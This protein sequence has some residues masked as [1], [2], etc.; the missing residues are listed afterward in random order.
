MNSNG[1]ISHFKVSSIVL[2]SFEVKSPSKRKRAQQKPKECEI[3][4]G[5][6][7]L[8]G[9]VIVT[10]PI[11]S[12]SPNQFEPWQKKH[13]REKDQKRAVMFSLIPVKQQIQLPCSLKFTRYAPKWLDKHDNLP[14]SMKKIVDQTC[15]EI[16]CDFVPGRADSYDCFT[17]EYD[18]VKSKTYAVKIEITF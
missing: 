9:S 8:P 6:M 15:A 3:E 17:I 18:Q 13:K 11:R 10:L 4:F 2:N 14:M 7:C 12:M 5:T 16:V 1:L